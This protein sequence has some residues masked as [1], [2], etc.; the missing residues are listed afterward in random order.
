MNVSTLKV[1][2]LITAAFC[3]SLVGAEL[4]AELPP[5]FAPRGFKSGHLSL[6]PALAY[7]LTYSDNAAR[8]SRQRKADWLSEYTP[9]LAMQLK[10]DEA[11]STSV[12][13]EFGWHDYV[14]DVARDYLSHRAVAD[15]R[16]TNL[17]VE[18]LSLSAGDTYLQSGNSSALDNQLLAFTRYHT[19]QAWEKLQYEFNRFTISGKYSYG[20]VDYF[21]RVDTGSDYHSHSGELEGTYSFVPKRFTLF[22]TYNL[23]RYLRDVTDTADFDAHTLQVGVRGTYAKLDYAVS[24]GAGSAVYLHQDREDHGPV[25]EAKLSYAPHRRLLATVTAS[26]R[27]N[28]AVLTGVTT[29]TNVKAG[30]AVLLTSR[31]KLAFDYTRNDSHFI[32]GFDELSLA[33]S[34]AFEYKLTR[35]ATGTISYTRTER[36]ISSGTG[37]YLINEGHVGLRLAW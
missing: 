8:A 18:G 4:G 10:P 6:L 15:F 36:D 16:A 21:A 17:F 30:L 29:D 7:D 35:Y 26:R 14:R 3:A 13:Y 2:T 5:S 22:G 12:L 25:F 24:V 11:I 34:A 19:N 23:T 9:S 33:Y 20:L 28:A 37:G 1:C 32:M 27:F 31:G